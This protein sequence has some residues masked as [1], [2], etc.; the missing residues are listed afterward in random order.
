MRGSSCTGFVGSIGV[1]WSRSVCFHSLPSWNS[2]DSIVRITSA[3]LLPGSSLLLEAFNLDQL[4]HQTFG[5]ARLD[6][7]GDTTLDSSPSL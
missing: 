7:G 4:D 1:P 5:V 2:T 3:D 6:A